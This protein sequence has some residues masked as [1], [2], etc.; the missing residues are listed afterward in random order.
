M[1]RSQYC[2]QLTPK[3]L[4]LFLPSHVLLYLTPP[5]WPHISMQSAHLPAIKHYKSPQ[6]HLIYDGPLLAQFQGLQCPFSTN[7]FFQDV[8]VGGR[9][10]TR[11]MQLT[12]WES[13][14]GLNEIPFGPQSESWGAV[15]AV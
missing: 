2:P 11:E 8:M 5:V 15:R 13:V 4:L 7:R 12:I 6:P 3:Y 14:E 1:P 10:N 9:V